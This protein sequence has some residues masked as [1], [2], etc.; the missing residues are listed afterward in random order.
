MLFR[1]RSTNEI[2]QISE[3]TTQQMTRAS[4]TIEVLEAQLGELKG[5]IDTLRT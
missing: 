2:N 5:L 1:S 3:L 4:K